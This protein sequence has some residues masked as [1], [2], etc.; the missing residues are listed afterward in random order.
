MSVPLALLG[1][2]GDSP[3]AALALYGIA[4]LLGS[5]ATV[6]WTGVAASGW[7]AEVTA[8]DC[9]D[10]AELADRLVEAIAADPLSSMGSLAKDINELKSET[11]RDGINQGG[12]IGRLV[13]GLCAEAPLRTGERVSLTPACVYSFGTRGTLFGNAAKQDDAVGAKDLRA[14]LAGPWSA[15]GNCNTLGFDPGARRQDGAVMG[16]DPSAD[17]VRGVPGLVPLVLRGL[18]AVAPMPGARRVSGGAFARHEEG[19]DFRWPV[20]TA[21]VR[22]DALP[23]VAGRNWSARTRAQRMAAGIEAVFGSLILRAERRLSIGRRI[24]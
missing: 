3:A 20:F 16:P 17:G 8:E 10:L 5:D 1:L 12:S 21:A 6:R 22:T 15:K 11:W 24:P 2:R 19:I 23:L 9:G 14:L 13:A 7:H 4:Y 18:A